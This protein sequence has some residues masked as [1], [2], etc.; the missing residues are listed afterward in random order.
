MSEKRQET[1][2][3]K[4]AR[5]EENESHLEHKM[6]MRFDWDNLIDDIIEDGR[7]QGIFDNLKGK[8]KPLDLNKNPFNQ[9]SEIADS[10]LKENKMLPAWLAQRNETQIQI[11]SLRQQISRTWRRYDQE[12]R[13]AQDAGIKSGLEIAWDDEIKKWE[14]AILKINKLVDSYNLKR[15]VNNLEMYKPRL[16]NELERVGARRFLRQL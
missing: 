9:N 4:K 13:F 6:R 12:Y 1:P 5:E 16:D 8:G 15:P 11:E 2:E 3:E 10:L 7:S 14:A